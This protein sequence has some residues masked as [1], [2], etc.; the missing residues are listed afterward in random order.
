MKLAM[1]ESYCNRGIKD[2]MELFKWLEDRRDYFGRNSA[3]YL[4]CI[5]QL[6]QLKKEEAY[7]NIKDLNW[8]CLPNTVTTRNF[9]NENYAYIVWEKLEQ[10]IRIK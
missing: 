4:H 3:P 2:K 6:F 7:N 1:M 10:L 9:I 5:N 8:F